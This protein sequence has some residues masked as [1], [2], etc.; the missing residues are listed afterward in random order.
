MSLDDGGSGAAAGGLWHGGAQRPAGLV[1]RRNP[2]WFDA[3]GIVN[4]F[5]N[6]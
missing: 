2:H 1:E 3:E 4:K 5:L 6:N